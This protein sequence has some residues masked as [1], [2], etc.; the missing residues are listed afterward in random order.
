[1][2][3]RLRSK[4]EKTITLILS[5]L[6]NAFNSGIFYGWPSLVF[7]L[8]QQQFFREGC[9]DDVSPNAVL[10]NDSF[11]YATSSP[12]GSEY[13]T[14][15]QYVLTGNDSGHENDMGD[16]MLP[17]DS[18]DSKFQLVFTVAAFCMQG[19]VFPSG[20]LFDRCGTRFVR[21]LFS[22]L[23]LAGHLFLGF[24]TP[25]R[26][27]FLFPAGIL[28]GIGGILM[29]VCSM[30]VSNLFGPNKATVMTLMSGCFDSSAVVMLIVKLSYEAGLPMSTAFFILAGATIFFSMNTFILLP[31]KR[32]PWPLPSGYVQVKRCCGGTEEKEAVMTQEEIDLKVANENGTEKEKLNRNGSTVNGSD[33]RKSSG[34]KANGGGS[35]RRKSRVIQAEAEACKKQYFPTIRSCILSPLFWLL[36][37]WISILQLRLIFM[38]G[39]LNPWLSRLSNNDEQVVSKYTNVF[40]F[41]QFCGFLVAPLGGLLL[42]RNK[43]TTG[44]FANKHLDK[45]SPYADLKDTCFPLA[46]T[47][48]LFT[49]FSICIVIPKLELQYLTF[50]IQVVIRSFLY[51]LS[52]AAIPIMFPQEYFGTLFGVMGSFAGIFGLLQYPI[53][54]IL[55][56][57][58]NNDPFILNIC[59]IVFNLLTASLPMYIWFFVRRKEKQ[60]K[61]EQEEELQE[62][63]YTILPATS[64]SDA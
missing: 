27:N 53:F 40:S 51:G 49:I 10:L 32:I 46:L 63:K 37:A 23:I 31:V 4:I 34:T 9:D 3:A 7:I 62:E 44:W 25:A 55:Q 52:C 5:I 33:R 39:T 58:L 48:I 15:V 22:V 21:I 16:H 18:Q 26:A 61:L 64:P 28:I 20:L 11:G 2:M 47:T 50:I 57:V 29:M 6:E 17:C 41:I 56:N 30:Q 8:K 13:V 12:L 59:F 43:M 60:Y 19:S 1:M 35:T 36:V 38:I 14:D 54:S 45:R 24:S 42:D